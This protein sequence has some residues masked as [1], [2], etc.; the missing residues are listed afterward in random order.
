MSRCPGWSLLIVQSPRWKNHMK[1]VTSVSAGVAGTAAVFLTTAQ[2]LAENWPGWRGPEANGLSADTNLPV[3]WAADRHILWQV[4]IP[5]AGWS[6]PVVWRDKIFLTTAI[7]ERQQKPHGGEF[8]A[9]ALQK[10]RLFGGGAPPEDSY[11]WK[12]LCLDGANGRVLWEQTAREGRPTIPISPNNTY[13]SETPVTDG[14]RLI[15]YFGMIGLYCYDLAGKP[16]WRRELG[17][18]PT[19]FGWGTGS[20]PAL[21]GHRLFVQCDNERE[22]FLVALDK[23]TGE[24]LWRVGR[25]EKS[26]WST[27]YIWKNKRRTELV[28]GGGKMRAYDPETGSLLWSMNGSG[29]CATTPVG[30]TDLLYVDSYDRLMG[31][32]GRLAAIRAGAS[33]DISLSGQEA[34]NAFVAWSVPLN[35]ARVASPL[36]CADCLY[37]LPQQNGVVSCFDAATGALHYRERLPGAAG[38]TASPWANQGKIFCLD[39][40]GQTLVLSP[41]PK[42]QIVATNQLHET[43]WSSVA[44]MGDKLLLRGVDHLYC[45]GK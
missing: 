35:F 18:Y 39:E 26:N 12:V 3:V 2:L 7:T 43:F 40:K 23:R 14:E 24:P 10:G 22:S 13:A 21:Q 44:V 45:I 19:Q 9:S 15:A 42:L 38:F 16:L 20:S 36:L 1:I 11:R 8:G 31:R 4:E 17:V 28:A 5:G 6:Q 32:S 33:G 27:P 37:V 34:T 30:N 29:R 25:E 41:G